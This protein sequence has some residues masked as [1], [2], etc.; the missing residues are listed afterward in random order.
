MPELLTSNYK[1]YYN[2]DILS[3]AALFTLIMVLLMIFLP[4]LIIIYS[5]GKYNLIFFIIF[6]L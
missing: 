3:C 1:R 2:N 4:A 5:K 6:F